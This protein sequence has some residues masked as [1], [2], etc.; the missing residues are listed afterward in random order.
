MRFKTLINIIGKIFFFS[1]LILLTFSY[2]SDIKISFHHYFFYFFGTYLVSFLLLLS[3]SKNK[4]YLMII[5]VIP[6]L[7][8]IYLFF[9]ATHQIGARKNFLNSQYEIR[10][11][12][13]HYQI[14][15]RYCFFEKVVAQK[16]SDIFFDPYSKIGRL[17]S[18]Q[19]EAKLIDLTKNTG[20]PSKIGRIF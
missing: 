16:K 5:G 7:S 2:L 4:I 3:T 10:A 8:S 18:F 13:Y 6:I 20:L 9:N 1:C 14:I 15:E 11:Y 12:A 19:F 17:P